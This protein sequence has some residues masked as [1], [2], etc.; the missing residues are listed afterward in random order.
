MTSM[1]IPS[2]STLIDIV[3]PAY[4]ITDA[5]E[6]QAIEC[7]QSY[8]DQGRIIFVEDGGDYSP[9]I[10]E[11][12][13]VYIYAKDNKGFSVNV[14]RGWRYST[15]NY[16]MIVSSD[17]YLRGGKLKSLCVPGKVTS[18]HVVNQPRESLSGCFFVVPKT[19]RDELG[20]LDESMR[21]YWSDTDYEGRT[22]DIFQKG[23]DVE[24]FHYIAQTVTAAGVEGG[25]EAAKDGEAYNN[26]A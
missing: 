19:V 11:L 20:M 26:R 14:N 23:N 2:R 6:K 17:T 21:T 3:I 5:L 18:P 13:D 10:L 24:I 8:K 12:S 15:A 1:S 7:I 22:S 25:E 4:T 16:A 9:T